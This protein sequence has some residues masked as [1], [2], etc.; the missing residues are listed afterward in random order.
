[1]AKMKFYLNIEGAKLRTLDDLRENFFADGVLAHYQ[2]G[3]LAQWLDVWNYKDELEQVRAIQAK[4][5][6]GILA[7][8]CRIFDVEADLEDF[9]TD[10][11]PEDYLAEKKEAAAQAEMQDRIKAATSEVNMEFFEDWIDDDKDGSQRKKLNAWISLFP[12]LMKA[13]THGDE[14]V[15]K[16]LIQNGADV[17]VVVAD[18]NYNYSALLLAA[19]GDNPEIVK[20]L[21]DAGAN[22]NAKNGGGWTALMFAV[23]KPEIAKVLIAAGA[24][25]NAKNNFGSTVLMIAVRDDASNL[26]VIKELISAGAN[27]N[28][29]DDLGSTALMKTDKPEIIK[30]LANAGANVNAKDDTGWTV[31]MRAEKPEVIKALVAVG[32]DVN[33]REDNGGETVLIHAVVVHNLDTIKALIEAGADVNAKD[34]ISGSTA[35]MK[36]DNPEVIKVLVK[37]GANINAVDD[38]G[39][40]ALMKASISIHMSESDFSQRFFDFARESGNSAEE[41]NDMMELMKEI[42]EEMESPKKV[43]ST[44]VIRTLIELGANVNAKDIFGRTALDKAEDDRIKAIL[45]AAGAR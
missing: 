25:V 26:N 33:A 36:T 31:L 3:K 15:V 6:R 17:N 30:I 28:A 45:R 10:V 23:T 7:E 42:N 44:E 20:A 2:S 40:T 38:L 1:M 12:P 39:Q 19:N 11:F 8:L 41:I 32:A 18:K 29:K 43:D 5:T 13:I 37:A 16:N 35:L 22:I 4:D 34:G 24:N 21:I 9:E 27:V 14:I